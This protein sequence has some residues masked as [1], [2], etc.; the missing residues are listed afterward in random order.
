MA[1]AE[2]NYHAAQ[3][4]AHQAQIELE[5]A[6]QNRVNELFAEYLVCNGSVLEA[7]TEIGN[8]NLELADVLMTDEAEFGR[9]IKIAVLR[10]LSEDAER[11]MR[12]EFNQ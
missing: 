10:L 9:R 4:A 2:R 8:S 11:V 5:T 12:K 1:I 7:L 3:D 6:M